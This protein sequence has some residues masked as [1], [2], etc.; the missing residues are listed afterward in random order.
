MSRQAFAG[1]LKDMRQTDNYITTHSISS[2]YSGE[3]PE[4][5]I[6]NGLSTNE[7]E[8]RL[9]EFGYNSIES[10]EGTAGIILFLRQFR[11]PVTLLLL[12]AAG[13]SFYFGEWLDGYAI[14]VVVLINSIIGFTME[15]RAERSMLELRK[16][17]TVHAKVLRDGKLK[18]MVSR[19]LST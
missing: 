13:F 12:V 8:K 19:A 16:L 2:G 7:A 3:K 18:E 11:S 5:D 15:F 1:Y 6:H 14:I 4:Q 9:K 10:D 17:S